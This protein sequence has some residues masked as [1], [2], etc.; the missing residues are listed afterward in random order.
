M[1]DLVKWAV[2]GKQTFYLEKFS[3][4]YEEEVLSVCSVKSGLF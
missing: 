3:S 2:K 4:A 1:L